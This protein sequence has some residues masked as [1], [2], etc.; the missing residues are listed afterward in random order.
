MTTHNQSAS[1]HAAELLVSLLNLKL[2]GE[3]LSEDYLRSFAGVVVD[4]IIGA[5]HEDTSTVLTKVS[6]YRKTAMP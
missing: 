4:A 2:H 5:V 1:D 3:A 6:E